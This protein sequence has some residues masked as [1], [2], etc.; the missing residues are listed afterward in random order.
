MFFFLL[1]YLSEFDNISKNYH[2][3]VHI[4]IL[5]DLDAG[6]EYH[7]IIYLNMMWVLSYIFIKLYYN[8]CFHFY[9][10]YTF[11]II[12]LIDASCRQNGH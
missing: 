8:E 7:E 6:F 10:N 11:Q 12:F 4:T 1:I 9:S 3:Y 5:L 2:K